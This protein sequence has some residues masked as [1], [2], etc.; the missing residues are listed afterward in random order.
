[1][2]GLTLDT[3]AL[4]ALE[5]HERRTVA[6]VQA[7]IDRGVPITVPVVVLVKWWRGGRGQG[8]LRKSFVLESLDAELAEIA[9]IALERVGGRASPVDATVMAS[10]ARRGDVVLTSGRSHLERL[11]RVFPEV[12]LLRA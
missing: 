10:A 6:L 9:G 4:I 3:G 2:R 1:M 5:R 8:R 11:Q 12:R 7:A